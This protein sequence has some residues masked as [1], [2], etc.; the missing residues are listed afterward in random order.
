MDVKR[1]KGPGWGQRR[2]F[3]TD[4]ESLVEKPDISLHADY[5]CRESCVEGDVT[6]IVIMGVD[7]FLWQQSVK[8]C[9][10]NIVRLKHTGIMF[11]VRSVGYV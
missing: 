3:M 6:P 8:T 4:V 9:I 1:V 2:Y 7:S 5:T 10:T 11:L